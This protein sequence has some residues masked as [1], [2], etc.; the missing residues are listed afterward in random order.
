MPL[1]IRNNI[2][3]HHHHIP[4]QGRVID[5]VVKKSGVLDRAFMAIFG[6]IEYFTSSPNEIQKKIPQSVGP[7]IGGSLWSFF[8]KLR[9]ITNFRTTT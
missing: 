9:T 3:Y 6:L 8:A 4:E 7:A 5:S 2:S 1:R